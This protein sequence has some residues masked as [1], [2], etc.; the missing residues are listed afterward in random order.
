MS[1]FTRDFSF[2]LYVG[3]AEQGSVVEIEPIRDPRAPFNSG[4]WYAHCSLEFEEVTYKILWKGVDS[5]VLSNIE[6]LKFKFGCSENASADWGEEVE[7]GQ[8]ELSR[9]SGSGSSKDA[10]YQ[11]DEADRSY[12]TVVRV[13]WGMREASETAPTREAGRRFAAQNTVLFTSPT[14]NNVRFVFP[15]DGGRELWMSDQ[16]LPIVAPFYSRNMFSSTPGNS[17]ATSSTSLDPSSSRSAL[18]F[19][20]SDDDDAL[21]D[22]PV[23]APERFTYPHHTIKI[24]EFSYH[25]Y[26]AV[27]SW[28]ASHYIEFRTNDANSPTPQEPPS[29]TPPRLAS[30]KSVYRLAHLLEIPELEAL[31]LEAIRS[32]VTVATV[33][34]DLFSKTSLKFPAVLDILCQFMVKNREEM[35]EAGNWEELTGKMDLT[36]PWAGEDVAELVEVVAKVLNA[37]LEVS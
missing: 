20:D 13:E 10:T 34:A 25:T 6:H 2:P 19:D 9:R 16:V 28:I 22:P 29:S 21:A 37:A 24:T 15:R 14:P 35:T 17:N 5:N 12:K 7:V 3:G 36:T 33:V 4:R 18:A 11:F 8:Y 30:A 23:P 32:Q 31:A 27:F 1:T 26:R